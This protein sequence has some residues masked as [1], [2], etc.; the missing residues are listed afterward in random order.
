MEES[1]DLPPLSPAVIKTWL[2]GSCSLKEVSMTTK[3][4]IELKTWLQ[5]M[6]NIVAPSI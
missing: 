5:K 6:S 3:A 2:Y 1:T 4:A